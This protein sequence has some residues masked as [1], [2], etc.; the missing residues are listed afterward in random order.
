[1]GLSVELFRYNEK[2]EYWEYIDC[3][4]TSMIT[5]SR[6]LITTTINKNYNEEITETF[7]WGFCEPLYYIDEEPKISAYSFKGRGI[8]KIKY[9][10]LKKAWYEALGEELQLNNE[11]IDDNTIVCLATGG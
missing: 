2:I 8:T 4:Y 9:S 3:I 11:S 10:I 1:M 7:K 5:S 6:N